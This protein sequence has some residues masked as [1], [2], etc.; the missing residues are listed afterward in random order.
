MENIYLSYEYPMTLWY[1]LNDK[2]I[3]SLLQRSTHGK[4]LGNRDKY[5]TAHIMEAKTP[6]II[7]DGDYFILN[8]KKIPT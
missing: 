6:A 2:R 1:R 4:H 7:G 5:H 8:Y 3:Q